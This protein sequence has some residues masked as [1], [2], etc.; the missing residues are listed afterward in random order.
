MNTDNECINFLKYNGL[1][2]NHCVYAHLLSH[3]R[4][5]DFMDC[6]PSCS[7]VQGILKAGILVWVA[8]TSSK[9]SFWPRDQTSVSC[10]AG[11]FFTT[12]PPAMPY[13]S[14]C[15]YRLYSPW[16]SPGQNAGVGS[17]SLLRGSSQPRDQTRVSSTA[18]GFF[19]NWAI[20][21]AHKMKVTQLCLT[22]SDYIIH[23]ILQ[24]TILE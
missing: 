13:K 17:L 10:T 7:S 12:E 6:S 4:V 2:I 19:T 16:N 9:G 3:V 1:I 23:G 15:K 14:L 21:E 24:A 5:Y 22:F 18:G 11:R 20:R 8:T